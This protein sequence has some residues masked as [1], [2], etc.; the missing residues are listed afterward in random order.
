[1]NLFFAG[2]EFTDA[3]IAAIPAQG[4]WKFDYYLAGNTTATPDAT[5]Y[6]RP[7][8]AMTIPE[9]QTQPLANIL[10]ANI[11]EGRAASVTLPNGNTYLPSDNV[12]PIEFGWEVPDGALE[13][14]S[15]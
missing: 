15:I 3:E 10:D 14:T 13:P 5:Q 8:R 2:P 4:T 7:A 9:L 6:Y 11:E 1:M 12:D